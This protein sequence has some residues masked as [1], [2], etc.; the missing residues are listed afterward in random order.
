M[1][2]A[3]SI[4]RYC[5][6]QIYLGQYLRDFNLPMCIAQASEWKLSQGASIGTLGARSDAAKQF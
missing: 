2:N 1:L 4:D 5:G 6:A 3:N